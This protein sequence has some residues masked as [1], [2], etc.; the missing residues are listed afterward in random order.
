[1]CCS[2]TQNVRKVNLFDTKY[3][4]DNCALTIVKVN[5]GHHTIPRLR[6]NHPRKE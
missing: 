3:F 1:M 4:K 6:E 2:K 5:F